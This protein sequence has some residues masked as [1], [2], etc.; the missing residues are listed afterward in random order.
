MNQPGVQPTPSGPASGTSST[1]SRVG[2]ALPLRDS[3]MIH[4]SPSHADRTVI[5]PTSS[6]Q[7]LAPPPRASSREPL[8]NNGTTEQSTAAG[9]VGGQ[10]LGVPGQGTEQSGTTLAAS[11]NAP[12]EK[13]ES[14]GRRSKRSLTGRRRDGSRSSKR[15][16]Q[17]PT[18][19]EKTRPAS[20]GQANAATQSRPKKKGGFLAFLNCCGSSDHDQELGQ[21]QPSQPAKPAEKT[22]PVRVQQPSSLRQTQPV[23]TTGTSAD[24][25]KEIINEKA[26]QPEPPVAAPIAAPTSSDPTSEKP[27]PS[28]DASTA[29]SNAEVRPM[30][31]RTQKVNS[32]EPN[33]A[34][35]H[36]E[37][38][39]AGGEAP[40]NVPVVGGFG[41][42]PTATDQADEPILDRTPEQ[43]Q[44]DHEIEMSD[45]G[46]SLPLS[47]KDAQDV[48]GEENQAYERKVSS[49]ADRSDLP[50]PP[51]LQAPQVR[52]E[53]QPASQDTVMANAPEPPQKWLLPPLRSEFTGRKCLVLDLDETLVHSSFKVSSIFHEDIVLVLT[54]SRSYT[55]QTSPSP[56]RSKAKRTTYTSLND[57]EWTPS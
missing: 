9:P 15:S 33:A 31:H 7:P 13:A 41:E 51:P 5:A 34:A 20:A 17:Q 23:S 37:S 40:R 11:G 55:R 21:T 47:E 28:T 3:G 45:S 49:D 27:L 56:S 43:A 12:S 22:Q 57:L 52:S 44:R 29:Q 1:S 32:A 54:T 4:A 26:A 30:Q 8:P 19:G 46:P 35:P 48:V 16:A 36:A 50:P 2:N 6:A 39:A 42:V 25:S 14:I 24:D 18:A 38:S 10:T 53:E